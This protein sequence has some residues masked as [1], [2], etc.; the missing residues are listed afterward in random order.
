MMGNNTKRVDVAEK[1][2]LTSVERTAFMACKDQM[3]G[4]K[5]TI[6]GRGTIRP[7]PKEICVCQSKHMN[8]TF[9]EGEYKSHTNVV[10][11]LSGEPSLLTL[12]A[13]DLKKSENPEIQFN[14]LVMT[15]INCVADYQNK[16]DKLLEEMIIKDKNICNSSN[17]QITEICD[18]LRHEGRI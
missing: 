4:K 6:E 9:K 13:P 11:F 15:T 2:G 3:S 18:R 12:H 14:S 8:E 1:Y 7:V 5:L 16:Q 17:G 10:A